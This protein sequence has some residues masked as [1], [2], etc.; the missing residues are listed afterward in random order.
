[1]LAG[2]APDRIQK[3]PT[4]SG[5]M[6]HAGRC[7]LKRQD[8]QGLFPLL[9]PNSS[10]F[11][12]IALSPLATLTYLLSVHPNQVEIT[13]SVTK[14]ILFPSE[15]PRSNISCHIICYED[16][17]VDCAKL[18]GKEMHKPIANK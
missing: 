14:L 7:A 11:S 16:I 15:F 18:T 5:A 13:L 2:A 4:D 3:G 10:V 8:G 17:T 12:Y 6:V 1:M 9:P